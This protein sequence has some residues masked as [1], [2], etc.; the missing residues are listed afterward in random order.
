[1]PKKGFTHEDAKRIQ[2]KED[3]HPESKGLQELKPV[4]Q[5]HADKKK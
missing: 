2:S 4:A 3:T 5:S 1:M